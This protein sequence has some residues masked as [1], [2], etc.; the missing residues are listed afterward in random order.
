[1]KIGKM[2]IG[3]WSNWLYNVYNMHDVDSTQLEKIIQFKRK[4]FKLN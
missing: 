2:G 1:M 3:N 4:R